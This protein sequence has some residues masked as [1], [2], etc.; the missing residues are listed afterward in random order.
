MLSRRPTQKS[1]WRA[2]SDLLWRVFGVVGFV[3]DYPCNDHCP[4]RIS[5]A[6]GDSTGQ[7]AAPIPVDS[8]D[9]PVNGLDFFD[10]DGDGQ[11]E[12]LAGLDDDGDAGQL[13]AIE[14]TTDLESSQWPYVDVT[15][16]DESW[17]TSNA[18]G[19]G[20]LGA[21]DWEGLGSEELLTTYDE[22]PYSSADH[23]RLYQHEVNGD[24][25]VVGSKGSSEAMHRGS[26]G[27]HRHQGMVWGKR[28]VGAWITAG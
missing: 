27:K 28:C 24:G 3:A 5:A 15:G 14:L 19:G 16:R 7:F 26:T 4:S 10:A 2:W 11:N 12:I 6:L 18:P 17:S 13:F 21:T 8:V 22:D 1:R 25:D 9:T 23:F 20:F